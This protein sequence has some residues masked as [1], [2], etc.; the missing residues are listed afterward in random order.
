MSTR[1][2]CIFHAVTCGTPKCS[3]GNKDSRFYSQ[4]SNAFL[5][6]LALVDFPFEFRCW[7]WGNCSAIV[8]YDACVK[9]ANNF[10]TKRLAESSRK[11]T[12]IDQD[13]MTCCL[14][15]SL[16]SSVFFFVRV[17]FV[18]GAMEAKGVSPCWSAPANRRSETVQKTARAVVERPSR[19][20]KDNE[21]DNLVTALNQQQEGGGVSLVDGM[22]MNQLKEM[23][24]TVFGPRGSSG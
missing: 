5:A 17:Q 21:R 6:F 19:E 2:A 22:S 15:L 1:I 23:Y 16:V 14:K 3:I 13:L 11:A 12:A 4:L 18:L 8:T 20:F 24:K 7:M 10:M 9:M